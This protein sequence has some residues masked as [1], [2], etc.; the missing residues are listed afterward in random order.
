MAGPLNPMAFVT[1]YTAVGSGGRGG[2][3]AFANSINQ[4]KSQKVSEGYLANAQRQTA[5]SERRHSEGEVDKARAEL[6]EALLLGNQDRVELA[7]NNLR[8]VLGRHG[9]SIA[10]TRSDAQLKSSVETDL[11]SQRAVPEGESP[12][13]EMTR[14]PEQDTTAEQEDFFRKKVGKGKRPVAPPVRPPDGVLPR[15][16]AAAPSPASA[17]APLP[18]PGGVLPAT[19]AASAAEPP[20]ASEAPLRGYTINGPDG[21]PLYSVAPKDVVMR[22]RERVSKVFAM[23]DSKTQDPEERALIA[24][25]QKVAEGLVGVV[26]I[27]KAVAEGLGMY[28]AGMKRRNS[29]QVVEANRAPRF[30]GGG[31]IGAPAGGWVIGKGGAAMNQFGDDMFKTVEMVRSQAKLADLNKADQAIR[32]A[33]QGLQNAKNPADQRFAVQQLI[34]AMS[35]LTVS[36]AEDTRYQR[37]GGIIPQLENSLAQLTGDAMSPEYTRRVLGVV[38]NWRGMTNQIRQEAAAEGAEFFKNVVSGRAPPE[39]IEEAAAGVHDMIIMGGGLPRR[40]AAPGGAKPEGGKP[41]AKKDVKDLY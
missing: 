9:Y 23:L 1:P 5:T 31:G 2:G 35:G 22:Q 25:G 32:V 14:Q 34:K 3:S 4:A 27:D 7:A 19:P 24:Q 40:Q 15:A 28:D 13:E 38:Q 17:A 26:P 10:E 33:E 11:G 36:V 30:G 16:T 39:R 29:L 18:P 8:A 41:A 37:L 21:K 20:G 12:V 6:D